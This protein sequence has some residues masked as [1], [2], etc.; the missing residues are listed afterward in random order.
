MSG[1][2]ILMRVMPDA[3]R[4]RWYQVILTVPCTP[5][6]SPNHRA[7]SAYSPF[8]LEIMFERSVDKVNSCQ[9]HASPFKV[10][11]ATAA[12]SERAVRLPFTVAATAN[13][14]ELLRYGARL[15]SEA[16]DNSSSGVEFSSWHVLRYCQ[17]PKP[18]GLYKVLAEIETYR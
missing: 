6:G 11:I 3:M 14:A 18:R 15:G 16:S 1:L 5:F 17:V 2:L 9:G 7:K 12:Y 8:P 10:T 13:R 4:G